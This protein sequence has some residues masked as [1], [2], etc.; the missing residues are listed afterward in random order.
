M[1][2]VTLVLCQTLT[3]VKCEFKKP[4]SLASPPSASSCCLWCGL[5]RLT[6][7]KLTLTDGLEVTES[8]SVIMNK[9]QAVAEMTQF[10]Q[11]EATG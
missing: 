1:S 3:F 10:S 9:N 8:H 7:E 11:R 2:S 4:G 6:R 5:D